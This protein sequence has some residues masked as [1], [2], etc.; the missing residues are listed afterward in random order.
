[1]PCRVALIMRAFSK[2]PTMLTGMSKEAA[3]T[4]MASKLPRWAPI[5]IA[6]VRSLVSFSM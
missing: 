4:R 1:M 6:P 2:F 5:R 3:S